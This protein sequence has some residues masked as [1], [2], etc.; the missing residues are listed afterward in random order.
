MNKTLFLAAII[1]VSALGA[2]AY[3]GDKASDHFSRFD[4]DGD[5]KVA[6]S[7]LDA[8]HK[9][10]LAEADKDGDGFITK[11]EMR[12]SHEARRSEHMARMFPDANNDGSV[13]RREYEDAVRDRFNEL[14][15]NGDGLIAKEEMG[16]HHMRRGR[17]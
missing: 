8:R 15:K 6:V 5:G 16:E 9:D 3:A 17:H 14:D 1:G 10:F 7:E 4:K 13:S 11:D 2:A 12:A